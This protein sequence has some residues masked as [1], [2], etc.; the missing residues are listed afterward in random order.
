[1]RHLCVFSNRE[2]LFSLEKRLS[3]VFGAPYCESVFIQTYGYLPIHEF[4]YDTIIGVLRE[5][6]GEYE[7]KE[8]VEVKINNDG[9]EELVFRKVDKAQLFAN[10]VK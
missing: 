4:Y 3:E 8:L 9:S 5:F 6:D 10:Q 7:V 1:M 2:T